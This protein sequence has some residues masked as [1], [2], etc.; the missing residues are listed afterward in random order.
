MVGIAAPFMSRN[1]KL[2]VPKSEHGLL[3]VFWKINWKVDV[4]VPPPVKESPI[5]RASLVQGTALEVLVVVESVVEV[6]DVVVARVV[7]VGVE[8]VRWPT[9]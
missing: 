3:P 6:V 7:V 8:L 9:V 5:V 1:C 4:P 2:E